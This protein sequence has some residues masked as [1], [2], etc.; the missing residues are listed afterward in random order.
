M[1]SQ[2]QIK[3]AIDREHFSADGP[4][5]NIKEFCDALDTWAELAGDDL[6]PQFKESWSVVRLAIGKS[7]CLARVIYGGEPFRTRACPIHK[8]HWS[9]ILRVTCALCNHTGW[10]PED[11]DPLP[12]PSTYCGYCG[13][14]KDPP[15]YLTEAGV[16]MFKRDQETSYC[17][18]T[19]AGVNV[20][21]KHTWQEVKG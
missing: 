17:A 18:F 3:A 19:P 7:A 4:V 5:K 10:I 13:R 1:K 6:G 9:G 21:G 20:R 15:Y 8:G 2:E 16:E 14:P 11:L 12:D